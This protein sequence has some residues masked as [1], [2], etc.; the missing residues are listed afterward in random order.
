MQQNTETERARTERIFRRREE[1]KADVPDTC[2][3]FYSDRRAI[4][5]NALNGLARSYLP[6][7]IPSSRRRDSSGIP[8]SARL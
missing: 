8:K 1:R 3:Q 4:S 5:R 2:S 7:V 6:P